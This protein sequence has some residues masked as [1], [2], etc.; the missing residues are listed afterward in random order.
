MKHFFLQYNKDYKYKS[1]NKNLV[2]KIDDLI[3][4]S[5]DIYKINV[6]YVFKQNIDAHYNSLNKTINLPISYKFD[7]QKIYNTLFKY[8]KNDFQELIIFHELGHAVYREIEK[9]EFT[10]INNHLNLLFKK[11]IKF[12]NILI[13]M[14]EEAFA[15]IYASIC[16]FKKYNDDNIFENIKNV[17]KERYGFFKNYCQNK[18]HINYAYDASEIIGYYIKNNN[19]QDFDFFN[20]NPKK[21][22]YYYI[23]KAAIQSVISF[24]LIDAKKNDNLINEIKHTLTKLKI[25]EHIHF[26]NKIIELEKN[27]IIYFLVYIYQYTDNEYIYPKVINNL[28]D[29]GIYQRKVSKNLRIKEFENNF[30]NQ[31][32]TYFKLI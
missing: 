29:N 17:R 21:S 22:L 5:N 3:N 27:P 13:Q 26:E 11:D 6:K 10:K 25:T 24:I 19:I 28:I 32:L 4:I 31:L 20:K 8:F 16:L 14:Y 18:I 23:N 9:N 2:S 30:F 7:N 15:D 12:F 1:D